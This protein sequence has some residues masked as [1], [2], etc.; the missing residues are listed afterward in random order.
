MTEEMLVGESRNEGVVVY[1]RFGDHFLVECSICGWRKQYERQ[2]TVE[3][4]AFTHNRNFRK[5]GCTN[6]R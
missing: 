4:L 5:E 2:E 6:A 1:T 3:W